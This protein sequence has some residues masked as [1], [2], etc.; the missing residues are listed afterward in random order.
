MQMADRHVKR[1]SMSLIIRWRQIKATM[2]YYFTLVTITIINKSTNKK[3]WVGCGEKGTFLHCWSVCKLVQ[4]LWKIVWRFLKKWIL[5]LSY[6]PA[7]LFLSIYLKQSQTL[8]WKDICTPMFVEVLYT[9]V[10][11]WKQSKC[12]SVD[13]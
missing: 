9:I 2:R 8:I 1:C 5:E 13:N 12:P 3:C 4:L 10:K 7:I 11:I 6:V